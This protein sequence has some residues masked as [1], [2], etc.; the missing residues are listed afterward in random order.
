MAREIVLNIIPLEPFP[1][2]EIKGSI[3]INYDG[4]FDSVVIN[5]QIENSNDI[6]TYPVLNGKKINYPY[7]RLSIFKKDIGDTK[8]LNFTAQ[9][10]HVPDSKS[11]QAKFRVSLIQEHKEIFSDIKYIKIRK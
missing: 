7:A 9:S 8:L 5:S 1:E 10:K 4:R 3:E 11:S 2:Q 6:F